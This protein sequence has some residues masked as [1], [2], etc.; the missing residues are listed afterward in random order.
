MALTMA[1]RLQ[2]GRWSFV[3]P[4]IIDAVER[5]NEIAAC[6]PGSTRG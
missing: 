4:S 5:D 1:Q 2:T 6:S 3:L